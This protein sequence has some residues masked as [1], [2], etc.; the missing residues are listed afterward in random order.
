MIPVALRI[1]PFAE[2]CG[3]RVPITPEDPLRALDELMVVI[4]ALCPVCP[5]RETF[6]SA[7]K[8]LL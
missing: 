2:D 3:V 6:V 8:M 7:G 5:A 4:E 1:L